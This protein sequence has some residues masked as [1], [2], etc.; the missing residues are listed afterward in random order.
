M[1]YPNV[2]LE[3]KAGVNVKKVSENG[4]PIAGVEFTL[5]SMYGN[6]Y[7]ETRVT[8]EDGYANWDNISNGSYKLIETSAPNGVTVDTREKNIYVDNANKSY[9]YTIEN[10][11][12]NVLIK[13]IYKQ[14][15]I[16]KY[17]EN[18]F[19]DVPLK[20]AVFELR[21]S[22]NGAV[23][24]SNITTDLNGYAKI[25]YP[26]DS[27][28]DYYLVE[29]K[30]PNG[31]APLNSPIVINASNLLAERCELESSYTVG[32][33]A[34]YHNLYYG[35]ACKN[36]MTVEIENK[37]L[38]G[39][40]IVSKVDES[41]NPI[42]NKGQAVFEVQRLLESETGDIEY[43]GKKY[44]ANN[45]YSSQEVKTGNANALAVIEN[46]D[47]GVYQIVEK[48]APDG[49]I[50][51]PEPTVF[52]FSYDGQV[53][54]SHVFENKGYKPEIDITKTIDG[55][56]SNSKIDA[57]LLNNQRDTM[58]V[59]YVVENNGNTTLNDVEITDEIVNGNS[60]TE[61]INNLIKDAEAEIY[62]DMTEYNSNNVIKKE[63]NGSI[64][65]TPGQVAV[66]KVTVDAPKMGTLHTNTGSVTATSA[67]GSVN[68][69]DD[70]NAVRIDTKAKLPNTGGQGMALMVLFGL[71]LAM[72]A[73][74]FTTRR[75]NA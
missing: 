11:S 27:T 26:M 62:N 6:S 18:S 44:T 3:Q 66:I 33:K 19:M 25:S 35:D 22:E 23:L 4:T 69:T 59:E 31:Y 40:L 15:G 21:E 30:A 29:T 46:M 61:Y 52:E 17:G 42:L 65:L 9:N 45:I 68:D 39:R 67:Y 34:D 56:D 24:Q 75:K 41:N 10:L 38:K 73:L 74:V 63:T 1:F 28:K 5:Q 53:V 14:V 16:G 71:L 36:N 32:D 72:L 54:Y 57:V 70:A 43:N 60:D 49:Y 48:Q 2:R 58:E 55:F 13:K 7:S 50:V 8:D 37:P 51:N 64:T 47:I 12:T 20:G